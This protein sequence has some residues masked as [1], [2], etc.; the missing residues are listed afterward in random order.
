MLKEKI[1]AKENS[2]NP[3]FL[4]LILQ[5]LFAM[6]KAEFEQAERLAPGIDGLHLYM[7]RLIDDMPEK[8]TEAAV[9][10]FEHVEEMFGSTFLKEVSYLIALS[11]TGLAEREIEGILKQQSVEFSQIKFQEILFYLYDVFTE[12][13]DGK[14]VYSHHIFQ[15][16]MRQEAKYKEDEI[17]GYFICYSKEDSEFLK[18]EGYYHILRSKNIR[19]IEVLKE[20]R[21][22]AAFGRVKSLVKQMILKEEAAEDYFFGMLEDTGIE[23]LLK[24]WESVDSLREDKKIAAFLGKIYKICAQKDELPSELRIEALYS[25]I[26]KDDQEDSV[27]QVQTA[28]ALLSGIIDED[29]RQLW[30][31]KINYMDAWNLIDAGKAE[32][33]LALMKSEIDEVAG[34]FPDLESIGLSADSSFQVCQQLKEEAISLYIGYSRVYMSQNRKRFDVYLPQYLEAAFALYDRYPEYTQA[35]RFQLLKIRLYEEGAVQ[36]SKTIPKRSKQYAGEAVGLARKLSD[37]Q[38]D[39]EILE[40]LAKN[41]NYYGNDVDR[42]HRYKYRY[43]ALDVYKRIYQME[44][45]DYWKQE[46]AAQASFFAEDISSL[47]QQL[48]LD[49][50]DGWI[51]KGREAWKLCFSYYEELFEKGYEYANRA[52][53][54]DSLL[55]CTTEEVFKYYTDDAV[56]HAKKACG[57]VRMSL[58]LMLMKLLN[59]R[60]DYMDRKHHS[61]I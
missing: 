45:T 39:A 20:C 40:P 60:K 1:C 37:E 30:K 8:V 55:V 57:C 48:K 43:E 54:V 46:V 51:V 5:R 15:E 34:L 58:Y 7:E 41:L 52:V 42:E 23:E 25:V 3:L 29:T 33:G 12:N 59:G 61:R 47:V 6:R 10:L 9:R 2:D 49:D 4:S 16:V 26:E 17:R 38:P 13:A 14:W 53:Y 11:E 44:P 32:E 56:R 35:R 27:K 22:W 36:Y 18:R 31:I 24:F 28:R 21:T 50:R 19:G